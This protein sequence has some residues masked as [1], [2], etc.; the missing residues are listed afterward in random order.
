MTLASRLVFVAL[1][2]T[3]VLLLGC[4]DESSDG[5]SH[6][7]EE[8]SHSAAQT[9]EEHGHGSGT[10]TTVWSER[11]E[12]FAEHPAMI[13][14]QESAPWAVHVTRLDGY[15]PLTKGTLTLR[16]RRPDPASLRPSPRFR[17]QGPF[18]SS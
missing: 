5:H 14:G 17:R 2:S 13:A 15:R 9:T 7:G 10:V 12:I 11:V 3:S 4:G 8:H 6:G 18:G 16:F 1:L